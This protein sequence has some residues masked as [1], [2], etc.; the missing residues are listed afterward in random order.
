MVESSV[1]TVVAT[2]IVGITVVYGLF[3]VVR[4]REPDTSMS[5]YQGS[6]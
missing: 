5:M 4:I 3:L 1:W 2:V 6:S